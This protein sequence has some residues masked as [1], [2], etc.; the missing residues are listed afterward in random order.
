VD[1]WS[2]MEDTTSK[3]VVIFTNCKQ[4]EIE[5]NKRLLH[6][7]KRESFAD[8]VIKARIPFETGQLVAHALYTDERGHER[9]V[10]DTLNTAFAPYALAMQP[11]RNHVGKDSRIV[12]I[13][14][15]VVDSAGEVNPHSEHMVRYQL[16]GPG[17]IRVIDN[18]DLADHG[19]YGSSSKKVKMGK[20]LLILQAGSEPGDLIIS[21]TAKGLKSSRV[22]IKS[23][24]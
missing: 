22:K 2:F 4:V 10:S 20:Q 23:K 16:D 11:D 13:T 19:P 5:L 3:E 1:H 15:S 12:H 9:K 7:L 18:G 24:D 17:E 6:T 14:T 8:G 21:A